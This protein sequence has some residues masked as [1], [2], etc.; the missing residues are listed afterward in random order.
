MRSSLA[1]PLVFALALLGCSATADTPDRA[2]RA[3]VTHLQAGEVD[4]AWELLSR[5]SQ[6]ELTRIVHE[7]SVAS[8]GAIPDDPKRVALGD[9][10]L[11]RPIDAVE[12]QSQTEDRATLLVRSGEETM[13]VQMVRENGKWKVELVDAR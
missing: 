2:F 5:R 9:A 12:I 4:E 6:D 3:F 8:E 10:E 13:P 11:A 1:I 7:R